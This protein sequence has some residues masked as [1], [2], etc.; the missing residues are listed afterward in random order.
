VARNR[1][2][3]NGKLTESNKKTHSKPVNEIKQKRGFKIL[4]TK[5]RNEDIQTN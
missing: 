4:K 5:L 1:N 2:L 3:I